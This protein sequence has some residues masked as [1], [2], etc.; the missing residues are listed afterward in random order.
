MTDTTD[1]KANQP[2]IPKWAWFFAG[3]CF[4]IPVVTLGGAIPAAIGG[5]SGAAVLAIARQSTKPKRQRMIHCGVITGSAWTVF[6]VFLFAWAALQAKH[7]KLNPGAPKHVRSESQ[8]ANTSPSEFSVNSEP[9]ETELSEAKRKKIY[10]MAMRTRTHIAFAEKHGSSPEHI[11]RLENMHE[12][13]LDFTTRF[14]KITREQL[15]AIIIEGNTHDWP[16][17]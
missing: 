6:V 2:P 8:H 10:E 5:F 11:A 13:R 15:D 14:H 7:P 1:Q 16:M 12:K 4:I 3:A 9:Q 17:D